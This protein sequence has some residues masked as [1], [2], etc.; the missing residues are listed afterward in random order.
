MKQRPKVLYVAENADG[1]IL[2]GRSSG[3]L[4]ID[5]NRAELKDRASDTGL[6]FRIV[7]F[8]RRKP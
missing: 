7:A 8:D 2:R 3:E 5:A 4:I 6:D 1:Y